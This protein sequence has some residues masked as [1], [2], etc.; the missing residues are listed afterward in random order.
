MFNSTP[1]ANTHEITLQNNN[2]KIF[3]KPL[4]NTMYT[5]AAR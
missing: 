2:K 4:N 5:W 3:Y 1:C